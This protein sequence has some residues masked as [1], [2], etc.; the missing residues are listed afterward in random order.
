[1]LV[2]LAA[3]PGA[4]AADLVFDDT[5]DRADSPSLGGGWIEAEGPDAEVRLESLAARMDLTLGAGGGVDLVHAVNVQN[6]GSQSGANFDPR[7]LIV[8]T[9]VIADPL[10]GGFTSEYGVGLATPGNSDSDELFVY[11]RGDGDGMLGAFVQRPDPT[12]SGLVLVSQDDI[13]ASDGLGFDGLRFEIDAAGTS[14]LVSFDDGGGFVPL[15]G[16]PLPLDPA[17]LPAGATLKIG[18]RGADG[19]SGEGGG[20]EGDLVYG[21]VRAWANDDDDDGDG[22]ANR[23]DNCPNDAN[24]SQADADGDGLG[25]A[26]DACPALADPTNA[27]VENSLTITYSVVTAAYRDDPFGPAVIQEPATGNYRVRYAAAGPNT[28]VSGPTTLLSLNIP[29]PA[30]KLH[31]PLAARTFGIVG[32]TAQLGPLA[33]GAIVGMKVPF[34]LGTVSFTSYA[35]TP[36]IVGGSFRESNAVVT[37]SWSGGDGGRL[38]LGFGTNRAVRWAPAFSNPSA[39]YLGGPATEFAPPQVAFSFRAPAG[40]SVVRAPGSFRQWGWLPG[41]GCPPYV[42]PTGG[43]ICPANAL[44]ALGPYQGFPNGGI[45]IG[46]EVSRI[47]VPEPGSTLQLISGLS[48]LIGLERLRRRQER[49]RR[50][51][52]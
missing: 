26:C 15:F 10:L 50:R 4:S 9:F 18:N 12:G 14:L 27:C 34:S 22:V 39:T 35:S 45:A 46:E 1:V 8:E 47:Y 25:D 28:I 36:G 29:G 52:T 3:A 40:S 6:T 43:P 33:R 48:G 7:G 37:G 49:R 44:Q 51:D 20:R 5:F 42:F 19:D 11:L 16:G 21:F 13:A 31:Y 32:A 17:D 23:V 41:A 2:A 30:T 24:P 38:D